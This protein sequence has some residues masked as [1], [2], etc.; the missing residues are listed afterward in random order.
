[1]GAQRIDIQRFAELKAGCGLMI[2]CMGKERNK[3]S[4]Y[5]DDDDL[6]EEPAPRVPGCTSL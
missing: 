3:A 1:M 2:H 5:D 6:E 4:K